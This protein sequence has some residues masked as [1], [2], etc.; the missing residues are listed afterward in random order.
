MAKTITINVKEDVEQRFRKLAIA[1]YGKH[2]GFL[3]KAVTEAMQEWERKKME[4]DVNARA[5]EMLKKGFKMEK[6][7]FDREEIYAERFKRKK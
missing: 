1:T 5:L 3:G 7:K 2:K 6:W 4:T